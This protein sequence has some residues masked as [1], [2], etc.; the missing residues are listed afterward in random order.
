MNNILVCRYGVEIVFF[1]SQLLNA[2]L[3]NDFE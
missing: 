3:L 2:L 1:E